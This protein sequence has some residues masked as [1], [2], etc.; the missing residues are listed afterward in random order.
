MA[1]EF[2][3]AASPAVEELD[4]LVL[5]VRVLDRRG[6]VVA[7]AS[8][9]LLALDTAVL[10]IDSARS[11]VVGRKAG[12]G[13]VVAVA[14]RLRS[15]PVR[16][17]V[18]PAADSLVRVSAARDTV[19]AG[20]LTSAPLVVQ[21]LDLVTGAQPVGLRDRPVRFRIVLPVFADR[22]SATALLDNDSLQATVQTVTTGNASV[23][24]KRVGPVQ[25]DSLVVEAD[26]MRAF[27]GV[28]PGSPVRFVLSF[29]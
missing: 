24:V 9:F 10:G 2:V 11:A 19:A 17:T 16:V 21:L 13:R 8:P 7:G 29:R 28:V 3:G 25:P 5:T 4:T 20:T 18:T 1:I 14:E 12:Q 15:D 26:A 22:S 6:E 23:T 27:G